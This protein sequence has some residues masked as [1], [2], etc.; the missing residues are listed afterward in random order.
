MLWLK[1]KIIIDINEDKKDFNESD[2]KFKNKIL[3]K[4]QKYKVVSKSLISHEKNKINEINNIK[5]IY[6]RI[7]N[8]FLKFF[9]D[10]KN[11]G[12]KQWIKRLAFINRNEFLNIY[13]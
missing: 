6:L 8:L 13:I 4:D 12:F 5:T 1:K 10:S 3:V 11:L 7:T 2:R 9:W